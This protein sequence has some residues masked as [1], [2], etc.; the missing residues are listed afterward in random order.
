MAR[1]HEVNSPESQITTI[2][3]GF[4]N[5][6]KPALV[7]MDLSLPELSYLGFRLAEKIA[8]TRASTLRRKAGSEAASYLN[9]KDQ[10]EKTASSFG[11]VARS[12]RSLAGNDARRR[13][14]PKSERAEIASLAQTIAT[15]LEQQGYPI[16]MTDDIYARNGDLPPTARRDIVLRELH[17]LAATRRQIARARQI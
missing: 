3:G 1:V 9:L 10:L 16:D 6:Y 7:Q 8:A 11:H 12:A 15:V 5:T 17:H 4:F 13:G 14:L 2:V